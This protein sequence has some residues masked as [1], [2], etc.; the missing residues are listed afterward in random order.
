MGVVDLELS[1]KLARTGGHGAAQ[2]RAD[3]EGW[4]HI[5]DTLPQMVWAMRS[6]LGQPF[7]NQQWIAFTGVDLMTLD[8]VGRSNLI[9][10]D[11]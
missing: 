4:R 5:L 2:L 10:A 3:A 11:D 9:H 6:D 1:R 8:R 7:Y